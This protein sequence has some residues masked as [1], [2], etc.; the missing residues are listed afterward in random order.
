MAAQ[1]AAVQQVATAVQ[2]VATAAQQ[3]VAQQVAKTKSRSQLIVTRHYVR[4]KSGIAHGIKITDGDTLLVSEHGFFDI[5]FDIY[6]ITAGYR[7]KEVFIDEED[8]SNPFIINDGTLWQGVYPDEDNVLNFKVIFEEI[9][10]LLEIEKVSV[11]TNEELTSKLGTE[12]DYREDI[13][14][15]ETKIYVKGEHIDDYGNVQR[16]ITRNTWME[17]SC[18]GVYWVGGWSSNDNLHNKLSNIIINDD[19][20]KNIDKF[21][22]GFDFRFRI[23]PDDVYC[24]GDV[25]YSEVYHV[26]GGAKSEPET[27]LE[28]KPATGITSMQ[29][30]GMTL[31][32]G[33]ELP[34]DMTG[35]DYFTLAFY[36]SVYEEASKMTG[37][38]CSKTH[39][40]F[41]VDR[42]KFNA[43]YMY[44][45][46]EIVSMPMDGYEKAVYTEAISANISRTNLSITP[47]YEAVLADGNINRFTVE[48]D[49]AA[50]GAFMH[51][52]IWK[53]ADADQ[54][55]NNE[56]AYST[57]EPDGMS[58]FRS[59]ND[60]EIAAINAGTAVAGLR[61]WNVEQL[62]KVNGKWTISA[63]LYE[64]VAN[65]AIEIKTA[66]TQPE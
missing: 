28:V 53:N 18:D 48:F 30:T 54:P 38:T 51:T 11:Y 23:T 42:D 52:A 3:A 10:E 15:P 34:E 40:Y 24:T 19:I 13:F 45:T 29:Q 33:V 61:G 64:A 25:I 5:I 14:I 41:Y 66:P 22:D 46:V 4:L 6:D 35:I 65:K 36:D 21:N 37:I 32:I 62:E 50:M 60:D 39:P 59:A 43:G 56:S 7:I 57:V 9:P 63:K 26:N 49:E 31:K 12:L 2:Q 20:L 55:I 1:Q 44:D 8:Y 47:Y 27:K 16:P 17:V 58:V